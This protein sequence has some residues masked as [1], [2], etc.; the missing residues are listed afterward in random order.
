MKR[1]RRLGSR[2]PGLPPEGG[3]KEWACRTTRSSSTTERSDSSGYA[4]RLRDHLVA[5]FGRDRVFM[6]VGILGGNDWVASIEQAL[7]ASGAVLM[8]IGPSW[9]SPRLQEP[10]DRL[11]QELEAAVQL[12]A[13]I[14]PVLVGG[15]GMPDEA[16]LPP[17][18]Q[19]LARRQAVRLT[20][21][22]WEDDVRRL[23]TRL[24]QLVPPKVV[25]PTR[26][27]QGEAEVLGGRRA[28]LRVDLLG[29]RGWC[30]ISDLPVRREQRRRT[31]RPRWVETRRS[32]SHPTPDRRER[33]S[34]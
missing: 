10:G 5:Q 3:V 9:S 11:R 16:D 29:D 19:N 4:G 31:R 6:D 7:S 15:A 27:P 33:T 21:E 28:R 2:R 23:S 8:I 25:P 30:G 22:G 18:L 20:D 26:V 34:R 32:P 17:S 13:E 1:R 14:I 24:A 12:G